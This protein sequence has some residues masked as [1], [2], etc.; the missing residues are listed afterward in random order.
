MMTI[1]QKIN[2]K[3]KPLSTVEHED[4]LVKTV[5]SSSIIA[6]N[7]SIEKIIRQNEEERRASME[8]ASKCVV[9]GKL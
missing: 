8:A 3:I 5:K 9:G 1:E 6:L 7:N 2:Q 4:T